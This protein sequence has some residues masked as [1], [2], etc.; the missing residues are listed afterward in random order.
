MTN[1]DWKEKNQKYLYYLQKFLDT[2]DNIQD[3]DLR[4]DIIKAMLQCDKTLT[5]IAEQEFQN[6]NKRNN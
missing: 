2:C 5:E 4:K 1:N 6:M 3:E